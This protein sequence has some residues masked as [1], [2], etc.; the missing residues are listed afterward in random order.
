MKKSIKKTVISLALCAS[1]S[2]IVGGA[3]LLRSKQQVVSAATTTA[4][5]T[6]D[7][8]TI[9]DSASVRNTS[10]NGIRFK[11]I[12]SQETQTAISNLNLSDVSYGTLMLPADLLGSNELTHKTSSILDVETVLWQDDEQTTWTSVLAGTAGSDL[13]ENYYNRPIVARSYVTGTDGSGNTVYYY[14][15]NTTFRSI[16][17]VAM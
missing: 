11:T 1:A 6:L 2:C 5:Y 13:S 12:L 9:D 3:S 14:T 17:Y 7:G 10:P 16:G 8:F 4:Y 15:E